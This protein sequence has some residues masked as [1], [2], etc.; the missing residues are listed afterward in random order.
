MNPIDGVGKTPGLQPITGSGGKETAAPAPEV[1]AATGD[2]LA[3]A[4]SAET[5]L[6]TLQALF[7]GPGLSPAQM[8]A[9]AD[10][11]MRQGLL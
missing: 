5:S 7:N 4:G 1:A 8:S 9:L 3:G 2:P 11:L 10:A 6:Q